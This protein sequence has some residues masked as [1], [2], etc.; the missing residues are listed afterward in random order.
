MPEIIS[1]FCDSD[2]SLT[3]TPTPP[4]LTQ[5]YLR[6]FITA[7]CGYRHQAQENP[8]EGKHAE[9]GIEL[10]EEKVESNVSASP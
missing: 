6:P 10:L 1:G 4:S 2:T 7:T 5:A 3:I 9:E 8:F